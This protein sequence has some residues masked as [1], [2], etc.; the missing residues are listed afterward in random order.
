MLDYARQRAIEAL[1]TARRAV[2]RSRT[3]M[4]SLRELYRLF[5]EAA[6]PD[7][8]IC[9]C[10]GEMGRY[11]LGYADTARLGGDIGADWSALARNLK[12]FL[13]RL[14]V[15]GCWWN[16]DPDVFFMRAE[17]SGLS[18]EE[19]WVLTGTIGLIGGVFLTSDFA[20]QWSGEAAQR[21]RHFWNEIGPALPSGHYAAYD[22]AG[23]IAAL[24][25]S[26]GKTHRIGLY[27]WDD[28]VRSVRV[29]L[30]ALKLGESLPV[31]SV[32][33]DD[34]RVRIERNELVAIGQPGRSLRI[35]QLCG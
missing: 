12:E 27:N 29:P 15:N 28:A 1:S 17:N 7:V 18:L 6:G 34:V 23:R 5:R 33:P 26:S 21:V 14:C 19:S 4:Q 31:K 8:I 9:A 3:V 10:I 24:R 11:A 30:S 35:V 22:T 13:P 2:N 25:V 20:S 16:G 32:F